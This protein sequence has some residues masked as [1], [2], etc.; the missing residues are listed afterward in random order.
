M[1]PLRRAFPAPEVTARIRATI[2]TTDDT[3]VMWTQ[4]ITLRPD[5]LFVRASRPLAA[6][7]AVRVQLHGLDPEFPATEGMVTIGEPGLRVHGF[8]VRLDLA[9]PTL[10]NAW[11][12]LL[13]RF[14]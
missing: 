5:G 11:A 7:T 1:I 10:R 13:L 8:E 2:R 6:G 9:T 3:I 12:G 4:T 14:P